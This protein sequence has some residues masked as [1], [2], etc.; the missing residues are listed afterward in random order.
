MSSK[1]LFQK[2]MDREIPA[3]IAYEDEHCM[4]LHD[5]APQA[6]VHLLVIPR[7]P[8]AR[9]ERAESVDQMLLGHLLLTAASVARAQGL[10]QGFRVVINNGPM[11]GESVPHLHVH[12]LGKRPL[13]WPPG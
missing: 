4:V 1:T 6:P 5:I 11:A 13:A 12:V 10:E 7:K 8:I 9:L 2:I 3:S